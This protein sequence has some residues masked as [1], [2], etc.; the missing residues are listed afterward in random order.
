MKIT[1]RRACLMGAA[2]SLTFAAASQLNAHGDVTPQAVDT[3]A[4]PDI[5]G[6]ND[7]WVMENPYSGNEK[8]IEIGA[9]AYNQ[10]C[11]RCHGLEGISGGIA[12]DL[13]YLELGPSGDEWFIERFK[14]GSS[15]DGKVYMPPFEESL[16]QKAGWTI[17]SWLETKY[18]DE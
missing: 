18:T 7:N 11:A 5:E 16:G 14:N 13:R 6:G 9:S 4:L 12:P 10:N 15:H 3:S 2:A 1:F 17:R 8:A